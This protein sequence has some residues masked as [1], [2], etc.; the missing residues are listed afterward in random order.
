MRILLTLFSILI[1]SALNAQDTHVFVKTFQIHPSAMKNGKIYYYNPQNDTTYNF[2]FAIE[3]NPSSMAGRPLQVEAYAVF[4]RYGGSNE[5][6][7]SGMISL[8]KSNFNQFNNESTGI[9]ERTFTL[10]SND[11]E[12]TLKFK[13]RYKTDLPGYTDWTPWKYSTQ[14]YETERYIPP[15]PTP[16]ITGPSQ[17]CSEETYIITGAQTVILEDATGIATLTDL[18]NGQWKVT[19][20]GEGYAILKASNGPEV[21]TKVIKLGASSH[22]GTIKLKPK[23]FAAQGTYMIDF[24]DSGNDFNDISWSVSSSTNSVAITYDGYKKAVLNVNSWN[25]GGSNTVMVKITTTTT[26]GEPY[27]RE[28]TLSPGAE[29]IDPDI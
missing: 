1:F 8:T 27:S 16:T 2:G 14:M 5:Y 25:N 24:V 15:A 17:I 23:L 21:T 29:I 13:Y 3:I 10:K 18:G 26:C 11:K 12:G 20:N 22:L 6:L 19:R 4:A 9:L 28:F 7:A